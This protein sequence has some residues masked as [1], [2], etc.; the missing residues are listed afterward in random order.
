MRLKRRQRVEYCLRNNDHACVSKGCRL[1]NN[2]MN[3]HLDHILSRHP[4][5]LS[6]LCSSRKATR[7]RKSRR[8]RCG[9]VRLSNAILEVLTDSTKTLFTCP[10]CRGLFES[11]VTI[12]CGHTFCLKCAPPPGGR[13]C[14]CGAETQEGGGGA[15]NVLLRDLVDRWRKDNYEG[16][17]LSLIDNI[18]CNCGGQEM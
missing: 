15:V 8:K 1:R 18:K 12:E 16:K 4:D 2:K 3:E 13:C 9:S 6:S 5:L 11:P 10:V 7:R 14:D 17:L